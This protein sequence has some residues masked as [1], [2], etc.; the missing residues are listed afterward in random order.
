MSTLRSWRFVFFSTLM[1]VFLQVQMPLP[2]T[3][4]GKVYQRQ[5]D[6]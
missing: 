2:A 4:Q 3:A 6:D 5:G 1:G